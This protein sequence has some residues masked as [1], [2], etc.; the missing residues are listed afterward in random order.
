MWRFGIQT[1]FIPS[2]I[3]ETRKLSDKTFSAQFSRGSRESRQ[4]IFECTP[5][6]FSRSLFIKGERNWE[7]ESPISLT[8]MQIQ[9][10]HVIRRRVHFLAITMWEIYGRELHGVRYQVIYFYSRHKTQRK[11]ISRRTK[12][13]VNPCMCAIWCIFLLAMQLIREL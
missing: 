9:R 10:V 1:L 7:R 4:E 3:C 5:D 6:R 2:W 12:R 8:R 11:R 13:G